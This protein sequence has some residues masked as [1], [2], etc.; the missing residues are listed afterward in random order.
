[1]ADTVA[2]IPGG[3]GLCYWEGAW[4]AVGTES[5]EENAAKWEQFGSGWASSYATEYDPN[6]AGRWFGGS[7]VDNQAMFDFSGKALDSLWTWQYMT[8]GTEDLIEKQVEAV[9][10]VEVSLEQGSAFTL[11]ETVKVTYNVGGSKNEPVEWDAEALAAV[12]VNTVGVYTVPGTVTL[13]YDLGTAE[14]TATVIVLAA[15]L[16]QNPGFEDADMSMYALTG[17]SRTGDDPHSG[18][19]SVH[20]YNANGGT[21]ELSQ[22]IH[23]QPGSYSFSLFT[24]GDAKGSTD[25]YIYVQVGSAKVPTIRKS[26]A[27]AGWAVWQ[28]PEIEFQV[29]ETVSVTV[30][31]H[32]AYGNGGWGTIDDL[33]LG[34]TGTEP[35][36]ELSLTINNTLALDGATTLN[37][38]ISK[39]EIDPYALDSFHVV[40]VWTKYADGTYTDETVRLDVKDD[41]YGNGQYYLFALENIAAKELNDHMVAHVEGQKGDVTFTSD[42][43]DYNPMTYCYTIAQR[44]T[45]AMAL[46]KT[47]ADLIKYCAAAQICFSYNTEN[48]ADAGWNDTVN[49]VATQGDPEL[50][51]YKEDIALEGQTAAIKT[52]TLDASGRVNINYYVLPDDMAGY[53]S[54]TLVCTYKDVKGN[55]VTTEI[56]GADWSY[57][58]DTYGYIA[59]LDTVNAGEMREIITAV[60]KDANGNVISNTYKTSIETYAKTVVDRNNNPTLIA[61]LKA[62]LNY[63][64]SAKALLA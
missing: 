22:T 19:K 57:F 56:P 5:W 54:L 32:L 55:D 43:K 44:E 50:A 47:C 39:A 10:A 42:T 20:F 45:S 48:P 53:E 40:V 23:L 58:N 18:S 9:E 35:S 38:I 7:A 16:L 17:G 34:L 15:N 13:S 37:F 21:V 30:G 63:G 51:N 60:V 64:T 62:M 31:V 4:I 59:T 8:I 61:L 2:H 46:R 33:Y 25:Q 36:T 24:Q 52:Y 14:A 28:N 41:Q 29:S 26:F 3:I 1:V 49:G 11:P 6:D 27:L 12:D